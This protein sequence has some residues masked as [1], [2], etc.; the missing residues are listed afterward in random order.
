MAENSLTVAG[1][2]CRH[3]RFRCSGRVIRCPYQSLKIPFII[4]LGHYTIGEILIQCGKRF[5]LLVR[6][7]LESRKAASQLIH[8][9]TQGVHVPFVVGQ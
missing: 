7:L 4:F 8:Y 6:H 5:L 9:L 2:H 1:E 3:L